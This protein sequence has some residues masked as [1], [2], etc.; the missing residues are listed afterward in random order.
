VQLATTT[1]PLEASLV[2]ASF[3]SSEGFKKPV[4]NL[5][6]QIDANAAPIHYEK[7]LRYGKREE[8]HHIF[9]ADPKSPPKVISAFFVLAV[10]AGLPLLFGA[11]CF[12]L[13]FPFSYVAPAW[14]PALCIVPVD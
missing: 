13:Q 8:I 14:V 1:S 9:R 12:P 6:V 4:F 7:P 10:L 2:L 11:V 3:G 5:E